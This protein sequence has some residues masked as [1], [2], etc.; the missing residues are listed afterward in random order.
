MNQM[1]GKNSVVI[2]FS[3]VDGIWLDY[4][5]VKPSCLANASKNVKLADHE[6]HEIGNEELNADSPRFEVGIK[7]VNSMK[8]YR[9]CFNVMIVFVVHRKRSISDQAYR[10]KWRPYCEH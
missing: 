10:T 7:L 8:I 3:S 5:S 6:Y 4:D 1:N 9:K 2:F